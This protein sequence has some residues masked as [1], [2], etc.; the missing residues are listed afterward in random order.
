MAKLFYTLNEAGELLGKTE[1][2]VAANT[3]ITKTYDNLGY[4]WNFISSEKTRRA[5]YKSLKE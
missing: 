2:E 3:S 5:F 1:D 4:S